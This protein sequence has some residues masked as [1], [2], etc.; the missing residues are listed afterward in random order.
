MGWLSTL[1][2]SKSEEQK[3]DLEELKTNHSQLDQKYQ[4]TVQNNTNLEQ[5]IDNQIKRIEQ[6]EVEAQEA[7]GRARDQQAQLDEA[8]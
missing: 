2:I 1:A 5:E 8:Y 7:E 4:L 6:L 3:N